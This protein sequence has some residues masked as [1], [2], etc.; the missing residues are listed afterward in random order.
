MSLL[1][2]IMS[3]VKQVSYITLSDRLSSSVP[4]SEFQTADAQW[5][6]PHPTNSVLLEV[7][8]EDST[9]CSCELL[10]NN[11]KLNS[12]KHS[13][14]HPGSTQRGGEGR[15]LKEGG[16]NEGLYMRHASAIRFCHTSLGSRRPGGRGG[17][18]RGGA[19]ST[20]TFTPHHS[21]SVDQLTTTRSQGHA[22]PTLSGA[23]RVDRTQLTL[24]QT[25]KTLFTYSNNATS[26]PPS[27]HTV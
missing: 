4:G 1:S 23:S 7:K 6:I 15:G 2:V 12:P 18:G 11:E 5:R 13:S 25:T 3:Y 9:H 22:R 17:E 24:R 14:L 20:P 16:E 19:S 8:P 21:R 27:K 10:P 26:P